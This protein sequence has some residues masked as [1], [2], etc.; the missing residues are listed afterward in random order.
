LLKKS[1]E[2]CF[3]ENLAQVE[4]VGWLGELKEN[5]VHTAFDVTLS[6]NGNEILMDIKK[7]QLDAFNLTGGEFVRVVG[8]M[9]T[10]CTKY[11]NFYVKPVLNVSR[12]EPIESPA[13]LASRK[14]DQANLETLKQINPE[15]HIFPFK[16]NIKVSIL[17]GRQSEVFLDLTKELV[18][19]SEVSL[20]QILVN[21]TSAEEIAAGVMKCT[22]DV[23]VI[24]RGGGNSNDFECF[25]STALLTV[26]NK[27]QGYRI[28]GIGHS[29]HTTLADCVCDYSA[30]TPTRAGVHI[31]E[32][33]ALYSKIIQAET[34]PLDNAKRSLEQTNLDL[35]DRVV[36]LIQKV[37]DLEKSKNFLRWLAIAI[38][39]ALGVAGL[40]IKLKMR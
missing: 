28:L 36:G 8:T 3:S 12:I 14:N 37:K 33:F 19:L 34:A 7:S 20:E 27:F 35:N 25:N 2:N 29:S 38:T 18:G 6:D 9:A 26:I 13:I 23:L 15:R 11:T 24:I 17:C 10:K 40:W 16:S 32:M 30:S 4:V 21:M 5:I 39:V 1:I 22:G 31:K